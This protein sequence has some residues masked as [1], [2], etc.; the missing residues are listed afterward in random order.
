MLEFLL[1]VAVPHYAIIVHRSMTDL[2][3]IACLIGAMG[4]FLGIFLPTRC[5]VDGYTSLL[6]DASSS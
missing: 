1:L 6:A 3:Y 5:S 4:V 2:P